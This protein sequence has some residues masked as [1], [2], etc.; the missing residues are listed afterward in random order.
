MRRLAVLFALL[1]GIATRAPAAQDPPNWEAA[2]RY[3]SLEL[4]TGFVPDPHAVDVRAGGPDAITVGECPGF[5]AADAPDVDLNFETDGT[6][7]LKLFVRSADDTVLL[8]NTPSGEWVCNDDFEG[9]SPGIVFEQPERGNY[10]VWVGTFDET[11]DAPAATLYIT[12]VLVEEPAVG[13]TPTYGT[14]RLA[15]GFR[16]DPRAVEVAAGGPDAISVEGCPG[17][18]NAAAPD[19]DVS[20]EADG[21]LPLRFYARADSADL[22]LLVN[23]PSG[24]WVCDDD[25][26]LG[27]NPGIV[28]DAP[29]SGLYNVWVGLYNGAAAGAWPQATLYVSELLETFEG[30][31]EMEGGTGFGTGIGNSGTPPPPPPAPAPGSEPNRVEFDPALDGLGGGAGGTGEAEMAL[32]ATPTYGTLTLGPGFRPDPTTREVRAGGRSRVALRAADCTGYINRVAPDVNLVWRGRG[33]RRLTLY[34]TSS[35][36]TTLL[37][38]TPSGDWLCNDD[39]SD[40]NPAVTIE[41]PEEGLYN[42]WVGTFTSNAAGARATLHVSERPPRR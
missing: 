35:T 36:D 42:I 27:V 23:T 8:V 10:N 19:V 2:P 12:E 29:E 9:V 41:R 15:S 17:F 38:N 3:A 33:G 32:F 37:V 31:G 1:L 4:E 6:L 30:E 5:I 14:V 7:P 16:P 11:D 40:S 21:T 34:V 25:S 22:V 28:F 24:G 39:F 13:A 20:F 18:I 26:D